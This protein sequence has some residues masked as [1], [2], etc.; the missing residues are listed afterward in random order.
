M[1]CTKSGVRWIDTAWAKSSRMLWIAVDACQW[2]TLNLSK[3]FGASLN[4][5]LRYSE[6][7]HPWTDVAR[8]EWRNT[9][10]GR[11]WSMCHIRYRVNSIWS[12]HSQANLTN[13]MYACVDFI[14]CF[15]RDRSHPVLNHFRVI[16]AALSFIQRLMSSPLVV[17]GWRLDE[18]LQRHQ[19]LQLL[20]WI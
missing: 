9:R 5:A 7:S 18:I 12:L 3:R 2:L 10:S 6:S 17:H 11:M 20:Q 15:M 8:C 14:C 4:I 13:C 16:L 19:M 1:Y